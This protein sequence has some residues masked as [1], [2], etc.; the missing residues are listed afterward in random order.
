MQKMGL[1]PKQQQVYD[2]L[3][4]YHKVNG[5]YPSVREIGVGKI[6]GQQVLPERTSPT[7]VHRYLSVLKERGW[8]D[9]MPGKAR[10]IT[11]L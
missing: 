4:V 7:S 5:Y 6:D 9:M 2:F 8:I 3:R 11:L 10:S 1:T